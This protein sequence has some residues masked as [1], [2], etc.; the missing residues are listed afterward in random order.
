MKWRT[1]LQRLEQTAE[2]Q[3]A[4]LSEPLPPSAEEEQKLAYL[5]GEGPQPPCPPGIDPLTWDSKLRI[6]CCL[7]ERLRGALA[8]DA[9]LPNMSAYERGEAD[10]MVTIIGQFTWA[11][12]WFKEPKAATA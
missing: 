7:L 1:R 11:P 9:Y 3:S 12:P 6:E 10:A 4:S 2:R 5:R 8:T